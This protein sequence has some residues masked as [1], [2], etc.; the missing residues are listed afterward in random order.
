[1]SRKV[2]DSFIPWLAGFIDGE[3]TISALEIEACHKLQALN[4]RG[5]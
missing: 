4:K 3:G 5:L 1:M 2:D